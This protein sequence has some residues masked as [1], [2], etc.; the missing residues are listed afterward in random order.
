MAYDASREPGAD[1]GDHL[2]SGL[3]G[4][5]D[6]DA[7]SFSQGTQRPLLALRLLGTFPRL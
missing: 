7:S 5:V 1:T 2:Q 4:L 3:V 6:G